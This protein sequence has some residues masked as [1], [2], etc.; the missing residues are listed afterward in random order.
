MFLVVF[1]DFVSFIICNIYSVV[2]T[3]LFCN[4]IFLFFECFLRALKSFFLLFQF[5]VHCSYSVVNHF[6]SLSYLFAVMFD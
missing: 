6:V 4:V 3:N 5:F 1:I 2:N